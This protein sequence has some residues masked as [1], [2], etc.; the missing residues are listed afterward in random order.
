MR[1]DDGPINEVH[2]PVHL[3][4]PARQRPYR[5]ATV[6]QGPYRSGRSRQGAPVRSFHK[7]PS[8]IVRWSPM[9]FVQSEPPEEYGRW[10]LHL[11]ADK[12]VEL[13]VGDSISHQTVNGEFVWRMEDVLEVS[14]RSCDPK[15]PPVCLDEASKQMLRGG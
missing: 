1:A 10:A 14:T 15:R 3:S 9:V 13:E 7:I 2:R 6:D 8:R 5:L 4:P 11:L 12:L